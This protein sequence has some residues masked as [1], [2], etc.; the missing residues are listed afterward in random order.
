MGV[1]SSMQTILWLGGKGTGTGGEMMG[2]LFIR[3]SNGTKL[4]A[5]RRLEIHREKVTAMGLLYCRAFPPP[6][7]AIFFLRN[8]SSSRF[9]LFFFP[10][11][12]YVKFD[13]P[14]IFASEGFHKLLQNASVSW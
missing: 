12:S 6:I 13:F 5:C 1:H 2:V 11:I 10:K 7:V 3:M 8:F 4:R 9:S 14:D